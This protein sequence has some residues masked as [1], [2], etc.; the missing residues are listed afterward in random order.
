M[1][2]TA[3]RKKEVRSTETMTD[4]R[5]IRK[6]L[7]CE[8][9]KIADI[10]KKVG[11]PAYIYSHNSFVSNIKEMRAAFK[12]VNPLICYSMKANSNLAVIKSV[13]KAGAGLDIVSG[14]ELLR[15]KKAGCPGSKIVFA[16]VGKSAEEIRD[17]LQYG[18]LFFD[19]ESVP[20]L[21]L[22]NQIAGKLKKKARVSIRINPDVDAYTHAHITTGKADSKFGV[23]LR[24]AKRLFA[25]HEKYHNVKFCGIHVHIG[26]QITKGEPFV[27]AFKKVLAF[28]DEIESRYKLQLEYLNLGGGL[29]VVYNDEKPQTAA[30]YAKNILPL[31]KGRKFR[32]VFEPGRFVSANSGIFVTKVHYVKQTNVKNFA[33]IDGAMNDLLR[34]SLYSAYHSVQPVVKKA[35]VKQLVYDVVGPVCETGDVLAKKR[36]LT[37][38]QPG[39][40]LAIMSA[41]AY[42]YVMSSNYNTRP[43]ACEVLV[44]GRKFAVVKAR[45]TYKDLLRGE[46]IPS[47]V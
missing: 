34:P 14:G 29:G 38:I 23:D 2:T 6:D 45:E 22:I 11:S 41:G 12:T 26:S 20:E 46:K 31:F 17:A 16:G 28:V 15:A 30:Q 18:I 40:L 47:F 7:Y 27:N 8:K 3:V 1:T 32:L 42:G 21:D 37:Q 13:V 36:K 4:F 24:T 44:K 5:Y 9:V 43:R 39:D 33:I 19:V 25:V 10:V 35:G